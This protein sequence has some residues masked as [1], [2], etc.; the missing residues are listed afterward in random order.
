M[1]VTGAG[2]IALDRAA[3]GEARAASTVHPE[4]IDRLRVDARRPS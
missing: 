3:P 1:T 2:L 4:A